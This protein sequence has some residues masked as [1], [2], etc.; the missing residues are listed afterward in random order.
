[1]TEFERRCFN[2][3]VLMIADVHLVENS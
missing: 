3:F 2:H 1:M